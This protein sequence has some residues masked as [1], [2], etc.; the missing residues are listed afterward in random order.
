MV[1]AVVVLVGILGVG[2]RRKSS[3]ADKDANPLGQELSDSVLEERAVLVEESEGA[4]KERRKRQLQHEAEEEAEEAA[5][6]VANSDGSTK[7]MT[8]RARAFRRRLIRE[9]WGESPEPPPMS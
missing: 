8:N 3:G 2:R 4:R 7:N 5:A 1:D 6:L 9:H